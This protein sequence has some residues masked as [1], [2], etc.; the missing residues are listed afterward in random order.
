MS[1]DFQKSHFADFEQFKIDSQ[2]A[3]L[4][5]VKI[6]PNCQLLLLWAGHN[7]LLS[8]GNMLGHK[9]QSPLKSNFR[10]FNRI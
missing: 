8:L 9:K 2:F 1:G 3:N 5:Q 7:Y 10:N 6:D 4:G